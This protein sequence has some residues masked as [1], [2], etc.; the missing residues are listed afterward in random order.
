MTIREYD[1]RDLAELLSLYGSVGW[2]NYTQKPDMLAEAYRRSLL[3]VAAYEDEKLVGVIRVVG[4]GCSIIF[5]QDILVLP[6][7][8]RRGIGT[9][10]M[11]AVLERYSHVYQM[12]LA[13][14]NTEKTAAFYKS[15]GFAPLDEIGCRG[16]IRINF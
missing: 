16:F 11:R 4:D 10:L 15:L 14:D 2:T 8:Q 5:I 9:A 7:Y 6:E 1:G 12:E 13:T 3:A